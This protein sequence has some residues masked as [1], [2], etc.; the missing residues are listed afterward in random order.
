MNARIVSQLVDPVVRVAEVQTLDS[1]Y[2][3]QRWGRKKWS[4]NIWNTLSVP[5]KGRRQAYYYDLNFSY[6][7]KALFLILTPNGLIHVIRLLSVT[8]SWLQCNYKDYLLSKK[9]K[10]AKDK[11]ADHTVKY[12][13]VTNR[14]KC[15][16]KLSC[17]HTYTHTF[18]YDIK[19]FSSRVSWK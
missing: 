2:Y 17:M 10:W 6:Y 1:P 5:Q 8:I 7:F 19:G 9:S 14:N 4:L 16:S 11:P 15:I 3:L 13:Q 18:M 12:V